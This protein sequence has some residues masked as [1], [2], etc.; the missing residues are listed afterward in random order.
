VQHVFDHPILEPH[1]WFQGMGTVYYEDWKGAGNP[2]LILAY[3]TQLFRAP[4]FLLSRYTHAQIDQGLD[5]VVSNCGSEYMHVLTDTTLPWPD[6]KACIEAMCSLYADLMAPL[7]GNDLGHRRGKSDP[8]R[9]NFACYMWWD[10]IPLS[11]D[12]PEW[13]HLNAAVFH[14]FR[15]TLKLHSEACLESVLHGL[16]I[17]H[18]DAPNK[19]KSIVRRFLKR[20]FD[21]SPQLREY[22]EAIVG[23]P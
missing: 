9:P 10:I 18:H 13:R 21:I 2:A 19:V 11:G 12:M 6:R 22:A 16:S 5:Y 20:R 1:W 15:E 7:Y 23:R 14:V 8:A 4:A 17:W 3:L